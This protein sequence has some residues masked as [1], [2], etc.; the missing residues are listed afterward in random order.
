MT[1]TKLVITLDGMNPSDVR[2]ARLARGWSQQ[3]A[4]PR[5]GVSQPYL[6]MLETGA[7]RLTPALARRVV[8]T[9]GLEPTVLPPAPPGRAPVDTEALV[10][11]LAALGYPGFGYRRPQHWTPRNPVE[12]LLTALAQED[13]EARVVEALPWL[14]L[15]YGVGDPE[16]LVREAKVRDLQNRLGFVVGLAH[17]LAERRPDAPRGTALRD[18]EA[19]LDRSRLARENTLC[20]ASM[21]DAERAWLRE[22][23]S[24]EARRWNLLTDWTVDL[25][26]YGT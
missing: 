17:R 1:I 12:V 3:Q 24:D 23:R 8:R 11:D 5:L 25:L 7:R 21:P 26:R 15:R 6:A 9:Y 19:T 22:H 2:T 10:G 16:W 13:L 20:R 14:L 4:A 18:L